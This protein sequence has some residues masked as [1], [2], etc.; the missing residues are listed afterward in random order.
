LAHYQAVAAIYLIN[1]ILLA[2]TYVVRFE[3][4]WLV[5][6]A[7]LAFSLVTLLSLA[8]LRGSAK[9]EGFIFRRTTRTDRRNPWLR[10]MTW[11]HQ[12]G[13]RLVQYVLGVV[14]L[15]F[16]TLSE[17]ELAWTDIWLPLAVAVLALNWR[18]F[19]SAN[20]VLSRII[21]YSISVLSVHAATY[22]RPLEMITWHSLTLLDMPLLVLV[23]ALVLAIRT[24]RREVFS[25]D[26]Q[27]IL[28][29]LI[30][31]A[32]PLLT[33]GAGNDSVLVGAILRL[34][35]LLY[36]AEYVVARLQKPIAASVFALLWMAVYIIT[37]LG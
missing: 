19:N 20:K 34:A 26:T 31:L 11:L 2:I 25:M 23:F 33:L 22:D 5:L 8:A 29:L 1:F 24:T 18:Y 7:Y 10:R 13:A 9:R 30:L 6:F 3:N 36:A 37:A 17:R 15:A 32:A 4:D 12:N 16:V 35:I 14:W 28:V 21:F 27:D